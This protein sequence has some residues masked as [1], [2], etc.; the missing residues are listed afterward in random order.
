MATSAH[1][2]LPDYRMII[3][4]ILLIVLMIV[5]PQGLFGVR[6]VWDLK[7]FKRRGGG[8]GGSAG[9]AP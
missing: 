9:G 5:R 8:L 7:V 6:E 2:N 1:V 3:Y 4:A